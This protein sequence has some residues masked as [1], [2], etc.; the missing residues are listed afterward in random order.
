[1]IRL[2]WSDGWKRVLAAPAVVAGVFCL[3]VALAL[4]L[5]W[6]LRGLLQAHLGSSLMAA[7]AAD[8]VDYDWWQEFSAQ[9]S[10]IGTTFT[11]SLI[12]FAATLDNISTLLDGQSEIAPVVSAL[13]LYL[14]GWTFVSGGILDRYARQ[15]RTRTY[16]FFAACGVYFFRFIRLAVIAGAFYWWLFDFVHPWVFDEWYPRLT[17]DISVERDAF[18]IRALMYLAFGGV[19][20]FGNLLF[21]YAK[22]RAV[23]EDRR[24]VLGALNAALRFVANHPGRAFGLYAFNSVTFIGAL[25][26]WAAIAP[27]AGGAGASLWIGF[28]VAQAYLLARLLLKLQFMASQTALFQASLAHAGYTAAPEPVWPDSPAA[29]A[30]APRRLSF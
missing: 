9:S 14:T 26:V 15:R 24:S 2:A 21:D 28:L 30:I 11:P 5:A 23:V 17:R 1:M 20:L 4:P 7:D 22:V 3:T 18:A 13:T 12:G 19:L 8:A 10:G 25:A 6:T 16:G 29:E 27:R